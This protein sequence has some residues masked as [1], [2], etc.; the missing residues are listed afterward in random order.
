MSTL[1]IRSAQPSDVPQILAFIHDLARYEK[2]EHAVQANEA[3]I[4][5]ALF[6]PGATTHGLLCEQGETPI[7]FAIY[8]F[9]F[10][11]WTG[12]RGIYLEDLFVAPEH[13]H[14]GAGKALLKH[15]A[16]LTLAHDCK[17]FEWSVL[18]WN[19]PSIRFYESLGARPMSEW[20]GYRIDG[21]QLQALAQSG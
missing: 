9:N 18:D 1:S 17:R 6:G 3:D 8:F 13:R 15:L 5:T 20:V 16:Q 10:S 19:E 21:A 12:K 2:A 11:T 7:G 14:Q 4:H